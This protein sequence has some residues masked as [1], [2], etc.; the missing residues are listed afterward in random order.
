MYLFHFYVGLPVAFLYSLITSYLLL[1]YFQ[2]K[3]K[4]NMILF[5]IGFL[6]LSSL[7]FMP[8]ICLTI[9][10]LQTEEILFQYNEK[11]YSYIIDII[12]YINHALN[13][14][15]YPI[16]KIYCQ[17]GY[18]STKYKFLHIS[19]KDW[20]LE[21]FDF[22]IFIIGLI[23]SLILR[24]I[25]EIHANIFDFLL[26]Y[27]NILDL[28]KVYI[29]IAYSIGNLTIYYNKAIKRRDE[30]K[31]FILGKISI[32]RR[33]KL[34]SFKKHF[35][36]LCQLHLTYI[37]DNEKFNSFSQIQTF[38]DKIKSEQYFKMEEL[39]LIEPEFLDESM[40]IKKLEDLISEPYEK[41][42]EYSRKLALYLKGV[43]PC[44][45]ES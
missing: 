6:H 45:K 17:S 21:F 36:T 38:I 42:K 1:N 16:I 19:Y 30:Y 7:F 44:K 5:Y 27:L 11:A 29:E 40:N 41:C 26:N 25:S 35:K 22:W 10:L 3:E 39:G 15:I 2:N 12:S 34:E 4:T 33:K 20:I 8:I 13:K 28:I 14:I 31:Y 18:I 43:K 23:V 37:K 32:Y 9:V 24:A